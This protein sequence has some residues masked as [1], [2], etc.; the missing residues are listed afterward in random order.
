MN[1]KEASALPRQLVGP[2]ALPPFF[3]TA[4]ERQAYSRA[5]GYIPKKVPW[6]RTG[7]SEARSRR[8]LEQV[9]DDHQSG[10]LNPLWPLPVGSRD[11]LLDCVK[12]GVR[13]G[14]H[15]AMTDFGEASNYA[16]LEASA[17]SAVMR[18]IDDRIVF[19]RSGNCAPMRQKT[20]TSSKYVG[21]TK[22]G[23][24]WRAQVRVN[25]SRLQTHFDTEEQA[26]R[27]YNQWVADYCPGRPTNTIEP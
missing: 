21:V 8:H 14:I 16:L 26:A 4:K 18:V 13:E 19:R 2:A 24:R 6:T 10:L 5:N 27:Q 3:N 7:G 22:S 11:A 25:G 1:T 17:T 9:I 15:N 12:R 20:D 23:N